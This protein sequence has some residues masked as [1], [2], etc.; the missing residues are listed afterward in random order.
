M[1]PRLHMATLSCISA[2]LS[3][4]LSFGRMY[5]I[6]REGQGAL[7]HDTKRY[8]QSVKRTTQ[9]IV[10]TVCTVQREALEV[11]AQLIK[12]AYSYMV[13]LYWLALAYTIGS[14]VMIGDGDEAKAATVEIGCNVLLHC[15]RNILVVLCPVYIAVV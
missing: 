4:S 11:S 5:S 7:I 9:S 13:V 14:C 12:V 6:S 1:V 3:T 15:I 10:K 2:S 8:Q